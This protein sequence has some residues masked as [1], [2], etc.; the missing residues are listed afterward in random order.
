MILLVF[1]CCACASA[2]NYT[3][4]I[5]AAKTVS[6]SIFVVRVSEFTNI[7]RSTKIFIFKLHTHTRLCVGRFAEYERFG[8]EVETVTR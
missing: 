7:D 3:R 2:Y 5:I 4:T 1:G 6:K 8:I